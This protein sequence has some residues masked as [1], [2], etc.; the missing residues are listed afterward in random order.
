L[1]V[2][3]PGWYG[4]AAVKWLTEIEVIDQ[5][6]SGHFQTEKYV[7]EWERDGDIER[8]PVTRQ[9]VRALITHPGA[10]ELVD[11]GPLAVRGL[12]WSGEPPV[13][14]VEVSVNGEAWQPAQLLEARSRHSWQRWELIALIDRRGRNTVR[15]RATDRAGRVQPEQPEWNRQGYGNNAVH[16]VSVRAK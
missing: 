15:A 5:S 4:V 9:R 12:A 3:V 1:R 7:Y 14:R 2:I 16:E 6:F 10:D 13:S 11:A 8:E